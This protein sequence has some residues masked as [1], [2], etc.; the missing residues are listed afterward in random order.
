VKIER[1]ISHYWLALMGVQEVK[2]DGGGTE[3]AGEFTFS[4]GKGYENQELGADFC[5]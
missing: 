4:Y 2:W 3:P 5:S 1:K